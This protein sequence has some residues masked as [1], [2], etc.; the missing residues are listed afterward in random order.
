MKTN[1]WANLL[2]QD[3]RER[4]LSPSDPRP[5]LYQPQ[6]KS[7]VT[8]SGFSLIHPDYF[9]ETLITPIV[10]QELVEF[11]VPLNRIIGLNAV[12][13]IN[14][15]NFN[16][17]T[18]YWDKDDQIIVDKIL[19]SIHNRQ[20]DFTDTRG[21]F[22]TELPGEYFLLRGGRHRIIALFLAGATSFTFPVN[23]LRFVD[24]FLLTKPSN[25]FII[26]KAIDNGQV[27]GRIR[28]DDEMGKILSLNYPN[29]ENPLQLFGDIVS[30]ELIDVLAQTLPLD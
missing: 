6:P 22:A 30:D 25:E 11:T 24:E 16:P 28:A 2:G 12:E 5:V 18:I 9:N 7:L 19:Q 26:Q 23:R 4:L 21:I 20:F 29:I 13:N 27:K 1:P 15:E 8:D 17:E 14:Q 10:D 3:V